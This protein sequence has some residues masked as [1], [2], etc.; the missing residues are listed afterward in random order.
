MS[1]YLGTTPIAND[2]LQRLT[3][4]IGD[5][6]IAPFGIDES[7][8]LRRYLN[9][10]VISQT[11]FEAFTN[12]VKSAIA[13]YPNLSATEE[14]WQAEVTA[15]VLGQCGKFVI[16]DEAGTIRLPKVVN[17][18]GLQDLALIGGIKSESLP[19]IKFN[20]VMVGPNTTMEL[21]DTGFYG[22]TQSPTVVLDA[23]R[24]S[25]TY[26]DGAPVQQEAIQYPYYI[27]VATGIE[28]TLPAIREYEINTPFFFGQSMWSDVD[29]NNASWL[30]SNGQYNSR[31]VYLDYYDWLLRQYNNPAE[32]NVIKVG[33]ITDSNGVL[34]GFSVANNTLLPVT[35][36]P[37]KN[38]WEIV[39]KFK[40]PQTFS[41]QALITKTHQNGVNYGLRI[42]FDPGGMVYYLIGSSYNTF[43]CEGLGIQTLN[44]DT[45]YYV[46]FEFTGEAY[47]AYI[48]TDT[49]TWTEDFS[50]STTTPVE[51]FD[52]PTY[53]GDNIYKNVPF[54]GSIDL[55]ESYINING[56]RWWN[57]RKSAAIKTG[58]TSISPDYDFVINMTDE[59]FRLPLLNGERVLIAKKEATTEDPTWFNWYS[60]GWLEQGG[61]QLSRWTTGENRRINFIKPFVDNNY[62]LAYSNG[63]PD[64]TNM[65]WKSAITARDK[66]G[67]NFQHVSLAGNSCENNFSYIS[68]GYASIPTTSDYTEIKGLY[69]YVGDVVQ[70]AS[71]I[72]AGRVLEYFSKLNT[73]HCVV[74]T[75]KSGTSWYRVYDDGWV[76]QGGYHNADAVAVSSISLLKSYKDTNY[77]IL[78]TNLYNASATK[79]P[80]HITT[81]ATTGF[82]YWSE[83]TNGDIYW[84]TK[85]YGA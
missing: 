76:E 19:N 32:S 23:S 75:F 50:F 6:G 36:S 26:Q 54:A 83:N 57:G 29:P 3:G 25:S 4:E 45:N 30:L 2:G 49:E 52:E 77:S 5:I 40:T 7:L 14:N 71:L 58:E 51:A 67:F 8:N 69:F 27:Q 20:N 34:S 55:N 24:V 33:S 61:N 48:S 79:N 64:M 59:T 60:D 78:I 65:N 9:G 31:S 81:V 28:E 62:S 41:E 22:P 15:S 43:I 37:E 17:L 11:Q 21:E 38:P 56:Q 16:D 72:N 1:L 44:V 82:N 66:N 85:G 53:L 46:K 35:F 39:I 74:E 12:K 84:E 10:Q 42:G 13:I 63:T 70:D 68:C 80:P 18:N 47:K 73:V